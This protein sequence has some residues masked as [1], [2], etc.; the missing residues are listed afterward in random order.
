MLTA[1]PDSYQNVFQESATEIYDK[2]EPELQ[3]ARSPL[4]N[5]R[6]TQDASYGH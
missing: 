4:A 3:E 2:V 6:F 5:R 1:G